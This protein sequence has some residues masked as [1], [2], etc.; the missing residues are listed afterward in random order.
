[1]SLKTFIWKPK[2]ER[3]EFSG[4]M[5]HKPA[6]TLWVTCVSLCQNIKTKQYVCICVCI[7]T[8]TNSITL[9]S[10]Y[11]RYTHTQTHF[12]PK[13]GIFSKANFWNTIFVFK[14]H[15]CLLPGALYKFTY[16]IFLVPNRWKVITQT[17]DGG[18]PCCMYAPQA[19]DVLVY[20]CKLCASHWIE[21][22]LISLLNYHRQNK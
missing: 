21:S 12:I 6:A 4:H 14:F 3:Y 18:V 17:N 15:G 20:F 16:N 22:S 1:M 8:C 2:S 5:A 9:L 13:H 10:I 7:Y 19:L 11:M